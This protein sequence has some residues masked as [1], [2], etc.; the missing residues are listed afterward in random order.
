MMWL[1]ERH[2]GEIDHFWQ[3]WQYERHRVNLP[4]ETGREIFSVVA[5]RADK[6]G[7]FTCCGKQG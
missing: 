2:K 7:K 1:Y 5:N 3:A 4:A 6:K